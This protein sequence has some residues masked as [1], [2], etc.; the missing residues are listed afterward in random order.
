MTSSAPQ[1]RAPQAAPAGQD[2]PGKTLGIVGLIVAIFFNL[3]GLIISIIAFNQSKKAGYKNTPA[4]A[5]IIVGA[6]FLGIGLLVVILSI[7]A[8]VSAGT[9]GYSN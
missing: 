5:G 2:F 6:V 8:G 4:L 7:V 9:A 3:I 1:S